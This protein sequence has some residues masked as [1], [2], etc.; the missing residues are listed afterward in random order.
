VVV[1]YGSL[2]L[3]LNLA[4]LFV[5]VALYAFLKATEASQTRLRW[6]YVSVLAF[7][8]ACYCSWEPILM[9][10]GL[11]AI[12]A[13]TKDRR[14]LGLVMSLALA[15]VLALGTG[16]VLALLT[17][18]QL[19]QDLLAVVRYRAGLGVDR[20]VL[21]S[22][23]TVHEARLNGVENSSWS[24]L[25]RTIL[26]R[27]YLVGDLGWIAILTCAVVW[28]ISWNRPSSRG[29]GVSGVALVVPWVLWSLIFRNHVVVHE[30]QLIL[31][32]PGAAASVGILLG[33]LHGHVL[34]RV[35]GVAKTASLVA[36]TILLP[37][38]LSPALI[39]KARDEI[40]NATRPIAEVDPPTIE[41]VDYGLAIERTTPSGS[42]VISPS[43]SM[44]P[45]YYS[46]RHI[47]R[48]VSSEVLATVAEAT[49][50]SFPSAAV[51]AA[52]MPDD[53]ARFTQP[54]SKWPVV[55]RSDELIL[56]RLR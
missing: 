37:A 50:E 15:A 24:Y 9:L 36:G 29:Y 1:E 14:S 40:K 45:V 49:F 33:T 46:H 19:L 31:L 48:G 53:I 27:R 28:A 26:D 6:K 10:P 2:G 18:P 47:V 56:L 38:I 52:I 55:H 12:S 16:L 44:I 43:P 17:R 3:P 13:A 4:I 54:Q 41:L 39:T 20:V 30:Y 34:E 7:V 8:V 23:H 25:A 11:F 35:R 51:F 21:T 42:V 32:A 5:L 22:V